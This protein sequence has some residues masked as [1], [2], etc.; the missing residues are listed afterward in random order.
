MCESH[1][2]S[3]AATK[4]EIVS[5]ILTPPKANLKLPVRA[6]VGKVTQAALTK[7][8]LISPETEEEKLRAKILS[9]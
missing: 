6:D 5:N 4:M 2:K 9:L 1:H 7:A 8:G 3:T